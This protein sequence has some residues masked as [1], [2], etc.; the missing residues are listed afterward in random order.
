MK[1]K[2]IPT[3]DRVFMAFVGPSGCGKTE[4][5]FK[6]LSGNTFYSN[7]NSVMFLY[8]EMQKIYIKL[9]KTIPVTFKKYTNLEILNSLANCLL[10]VDGSCEENYNEKEFVKLATEGRH[11]NINVIYKNYNFYQLS[12]WS[13]TI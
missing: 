12:K 10:I 8:R 1:K 3:Q 13:R 4:L 6:M 5:I 2:I 7:F 9:E 11:K